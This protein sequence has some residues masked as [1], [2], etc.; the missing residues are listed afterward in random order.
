MKRNVKHPVTTPGQFAESKSTQSVPS[1]V[2]VGVLAASPALV[3]KSH[4]FTVTHGQDHMD[5]TGS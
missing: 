5:P 1:V 2:K 4:T 3:D